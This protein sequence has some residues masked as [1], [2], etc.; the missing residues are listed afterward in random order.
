MCSVEDYRQLVD[1]VC[2]SGSF[3]P[4]LYPEVT[5]S[6]DTM[7]NKSPDGWTLLT[8]CVHL[9]PD[10]IQSERLIRFFVDHE[11]I[12]RDA[13]GDAGER[14]HVAKEAIGAMVKLSIAVSVRGV[15]RI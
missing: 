11:P 3:N 2:A 1:E 14:E 6:I 5:L 13:S 4:E 10:R 15:I 9:D 7:R 8:Y 12:I